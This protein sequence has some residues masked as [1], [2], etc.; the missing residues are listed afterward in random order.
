[1]IY[2]CVCVCVC[3]D[4]VSRRFMWDFI[5]ETMSHRAVILTT[6]RCVCVCVCVCVHALIVS[7]LI[8]H[9]MNNNDTNAHHMMI[10]IIIINN[11]NNNK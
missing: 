7:F 3:L 6:H 10:I 8:D 11:N 2:M 4:P 1:M 5:T 9:R